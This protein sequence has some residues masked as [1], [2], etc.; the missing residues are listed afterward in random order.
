MEVFQCDGCDFRVLFYEDFKA[1]I[2]DVY[3]VFLQLIDV[4]EDNVNELRSGFMN[5]SDQIEVEF[6]FIKDEF[7]IVE[8]LL[9]KSVLNLVF[10]IYFIVFIF[11]FSLQLWFLKYVVFIEFFVFCEL[12]L[13]F[14][15]RV[16]FVEYSRLLFFR[17]FYVFQFFFNL[18]NKIMFWKVLE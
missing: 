2:Q 6:F 18:E 17:F 3:T 15:C 12:F 16:C 10:L 7:V 9:G 1:Y 14:G 11:I 13:W 8:D 4:V 5:V